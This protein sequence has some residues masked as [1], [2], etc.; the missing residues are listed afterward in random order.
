MWLNKCN[1]IQ[2]KIL[3]S[4]LFQQF[5]LKL[6]WWQWSQ[7]GCCF[8]HFEKQQTFVFLFFFF[9]FFKFSFQSF[10]FFANSLDTEMFHTNTIF[11]CLNLWAKNLNVWLINYS[12]LKCYLTF[13]KKSFYP[14]VNI[15]SIKCQKKIHAWSSN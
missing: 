10:S 13:S 2:L 4:P 15:F 12:P 6:P 11:K 7:A 8:F 1:R 3:M 5:R 14:P 9:I